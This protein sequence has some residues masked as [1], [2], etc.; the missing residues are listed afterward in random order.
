[1]DLEYER[2]Q[3]VK[4]DRDI[5]DGRERVA[6]Q[7]KILNELDRDGH[8]TKM[9]RDLLDALHGTLNAMIEHR[10]LIVERIKALEQGRP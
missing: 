6:H 8:D 4:A 2:R 10:L 7:E 3:L 1:M 5:A 9:A